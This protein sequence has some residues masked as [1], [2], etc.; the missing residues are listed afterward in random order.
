MD[1]VRRQLQN[2]KTEID[3]LRQ[4]NSSLVETINSLE[5]LTRRGSSE[6]SLSGDCNTVLPNM[7][8]FSTTLGSGEF[9]KTIDS[10]QSTQI[11]EGILQLQRHLSKFRV[12]SK[13]FEDISNIFRASYLNLVTAPNSSSE[14][15][16]M[17]LLVANSSSYSS[18]ID[19]LRKSYEE[20]MSILEEQIES[21]LGV[22]RQNNSY[23]T[24]LRSRLEDSLKALYRY[25]IEV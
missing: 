9:L 5:V 2:A 24:E 23:M 6:N 18:L 25:V 21:C 13:M 19:V 1:K 4:K 17:A 7:S 10:Q 22:I 15:K 11:H 12:R 20:S 16:A 8:L 3:S 14:S